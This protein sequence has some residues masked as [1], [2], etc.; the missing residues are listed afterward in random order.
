[1]DA[2]YKYD[3]KNKS[4]GFDRVKMYEKWD[5]ARGQANLEWARGL[6]RDMFS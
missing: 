4:F 1:M 6:Y 3:P 2:Y 5:K